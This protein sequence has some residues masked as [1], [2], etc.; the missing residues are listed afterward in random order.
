M[1][2]PIFLMAVYCIDVYQKG[3][4][5]VDMGKYLYGGERTFDNIYL[6]FCFCTPIMLKWKVLGFSFQR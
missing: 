4:S 1:A 5:D 2:L 3:L 6:D